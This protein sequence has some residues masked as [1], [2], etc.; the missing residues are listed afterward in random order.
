M[1]IIVYKT[2]RLREEMF[3]QDGDPFDSYE[4]NVGCDSKSI[5]KKLIQLIG[6]VPDV[7]EK[8]VAKIGWFVYRLDKPFTNVES[9]LNEFLCNKVKLKEIATYYY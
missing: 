2:K 4:V 8:Y 3:V 9:L 6:H 5:N 1:K 7:D